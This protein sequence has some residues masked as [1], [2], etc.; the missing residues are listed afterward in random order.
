MR[1]ENA[2]ADR[3]RVENASGCLSHTASASGG[4]AH[5]KRVAGMPRVQQARRGKATCA[6]SASR[7]GHVRGKRV[8]RSA[9]KQQRTGNNRRLT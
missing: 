6:T 7:E 5:D 8:R 4:Q 3:L 1:S 9:H 2:S